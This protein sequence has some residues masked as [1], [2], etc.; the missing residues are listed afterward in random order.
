[1]VFTFPSLTFGWIIFLRYAR[2]L[3]RLR[4][5]TVGDGRPH[6]YRGRLLLCSDLR[7]LHEREKV[8]RPTVL[9]AVPASHL[10]PQKAL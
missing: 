7:Q 10:Q 5:V 8:G 4:V 3:L 9:A 1:M 2:V 6:P